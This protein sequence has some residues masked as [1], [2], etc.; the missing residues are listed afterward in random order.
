MQEAKNSQCNLEDEE[1][2]GLT[3]PDIMTYYNNT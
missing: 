2:K 3:L 1:D